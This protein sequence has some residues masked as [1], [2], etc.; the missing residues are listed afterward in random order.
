MINVIF[1]IAIPALACVTLTACGGS[2]TGVSSFDTIATKGQQL[3]ADYGTEA[4]T[5]VGSM[6]VS[7]S[8][9]YNGAAAYSSQFSNAADISINATTVSDI[10]L[11]A[12]FAASTI[13]GVADNFHTRVSP[14]IS[15]D[16]QLNLVGTITGNTFS[17]NLNGTVTETIS[18][19]T[20]DAAALNGLSLPVV[21]SG[22]TTGEFVG[23]NA[24]ALRGVGT[25]IGATSYEGQA[26]SITVNAIFGG[27]TE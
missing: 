20:G 14:N 12:N 23:S 21:Y 1:K 26:L 16:G 27:V 15:L 17:T 10:S 18:G 19:M 25:G 9:T 13:T 8:A 6:P 5:D 4:V 7:G 2:S 11:S 3:I 24:G 22:N